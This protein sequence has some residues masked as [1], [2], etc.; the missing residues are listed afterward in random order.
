MAAAEA[1][2]ILFMVKMKTS[3]RNKMA[4]D[5]RNSGK[6][7]REIGYF[8]GFSATRARQLV[9]A[10]KNRIENLSNNN[11]IRE[12]QKID[13]PQLARTINC[14]NNHFG[15]IENIDPNIIASMGFKYLLKIKNFGK[16]CGYDVATALENIG[17]IQDA[18]EW[19][20][21][22][23]NINGFHRKV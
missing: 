17:I 2:V 8:F 6:T 10:H 19:C 3:V 7:Y 23:Y 14:L 15:E 11:F 5:L 16:K 20:E 1:E 13:S 21:R 12:L 4:W 22:K 18:N 9:F